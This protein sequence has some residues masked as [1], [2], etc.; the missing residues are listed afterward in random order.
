M[1]AKAVYGG[2]GGRARW[3]DIWYDFQVCNKEKLL[4]HAELK[5]VIELE[6]LPRAEKPSR[7]LGN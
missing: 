5:Q 4:S 1:A 6:L 3:T 7:Y 2:E